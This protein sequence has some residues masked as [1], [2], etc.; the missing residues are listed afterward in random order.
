MHAPFIRYAIHVPSMRHGLLNRGEDVR[1][2][3]AAADVSAHQFPDLICGRGMAFAHH[4]DGGTDLSRR[5]VATLECVV[6]NECLL[7]RMERTVLRET[8]DGHDLGAVLH[9]GQRHTRVD[10]LAVDEHGAS[11]ALSV[12]A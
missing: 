9:D 5:A 12:V 6:L 2:G 8:L 11:A 7:Q 10:A 4:S 1:I 3:A